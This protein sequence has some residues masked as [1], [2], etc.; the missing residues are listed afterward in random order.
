ME[1]C[2]KPNLHSYRIH[3][4]TLTP[5]AKEIAWIAPEPFEKE[6]HCLIL[7]WPLE[8]QESDRNFSGDRVLSRAIC[9]FIFLPLL[10]LVLLALI[11]DISVILNQPT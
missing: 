2:G 4:Q 6:V 1:G 7:T 5:R 3:T 9:L 8:G 11:S 10:H